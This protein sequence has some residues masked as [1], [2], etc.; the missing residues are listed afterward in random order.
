MRTKM[1][2]LAIAYIA[3]SGLLLAI[4]HQSSGP[5]TTEKTD[6]AGGAGSGSEFLAERFAG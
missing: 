4:A 1:T 3:I 6:R 5:V 2:I